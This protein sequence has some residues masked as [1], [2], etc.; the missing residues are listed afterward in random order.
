MN[1]NIEE[2]TLIDIIKYPILTDKTT[3]MIEDNKYY[4]AVE[5][6]A[7]KSKIKQAIEELFKVKVKKINTLRIKPKKK[8]IGKYIGYKKI[9]KKAIIKL[10]NEYKIDLFVDN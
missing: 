1:N 6:K 5:V 7:K 2:L 10:H 4:F 9:Y 8:R 3:Q